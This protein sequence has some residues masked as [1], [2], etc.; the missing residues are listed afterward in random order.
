MFS[1]AGMLSAEAQPEPSCSYSSIAPKKK[2]LKRK[3]VN[4]VQEDPEPQLMERPKKRRRTE[5]TED[6][7]RK[8]KRKRQK[9]GA[10]PLKRKYLH[11]GLSQ[12]LPYI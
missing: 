9:T 6:S 4:V 7:V 5:T 1:L 2:P 12:V 11:K 10:R 8:E 3:R